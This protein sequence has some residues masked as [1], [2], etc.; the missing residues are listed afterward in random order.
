VLLK[1]LKDHPEIR[2]KSSSVLAIDAFSKA[3]QCR[4]GDPNT[5]RRV[6]FFDSGNRMFDACSAEISDSSDSETDANDVPKSLHCG[7]TTRAYLDMMIALGYKCSNLSG[8]TNQQLRDV[9]LKYRKERPE[10]RNYSGG[11]LAIEA[12]GQAFQCRI[13]R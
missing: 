4:P 7:M 3:F 6:N 12:Y 8:V 10:I 5:R 2:H 11:T 1:Y 9:Y 13:E